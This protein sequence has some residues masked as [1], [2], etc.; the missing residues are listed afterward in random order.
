MQFRAEAF[1]LNNHTN[2]GFVNGGFPAGANGLNQSSTF[3]TITSSRAAR[4]VQL[5]MKLIF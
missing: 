5:G 3:G 2:L 4:S 1:N